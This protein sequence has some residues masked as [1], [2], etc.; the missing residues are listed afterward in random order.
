VTSA[1]LAAFAVTCV[2]LAVTPGP[3]MSL[4]IANTLA[5]GFSGG[6]ATLAGTGTGLA[7]LVAVAAVGMTSVMVLMADWFDVVRWVGALY[8]VWLGARQL[9]GFWRRRR[10]MIAERPESSA[11]SCYLQGLLVS[12]S[13]PKVLLFLGAFLPQFV[14]PAA[15][16]APQ[17]AVLAVL[18]VAI[19]V[20]VDLAY[21]LV[22][23]RARRALD[24][25]RLSLLDGVAGALLVVGGLVLAA[26][27]RP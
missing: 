22:V 23:A 6:V 13:N 4:I 16:P 25:E 19:L 2:L 5:R 3:N 27:R 9:V 1:T 15:E 7:I 26:A 11:G 12:L 20:I 14:D 17:L 10:G 8:L 21:T 24:P 18:F